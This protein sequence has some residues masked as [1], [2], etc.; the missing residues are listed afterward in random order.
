[1][2]LDTNEEKRR[3]LKARFTRLKVIEEERIRQMSI[4]KTST[5]PQQGWGW[6][7]CH[8]SYNPFNHNPDDKVHER[9]QIEYANVY[10][11]EYD[12]NEPEPEILANGNTNTDVEITKLLRNM[13]SNRGRNRGRSTVVSNDL[14]QTSTI[15]APTEKPLGDFE[16]NVNSY[17]LHKTFFQNYE[18]NKTLPVYKH[19]NQI[20]NSINSYSTIIIE[21]L[22][23]CG[24]TTQVPLYILEDAILDRKCHKSPVIYVTQPRRIAAKSIAERVCYEHNWVVGKGPVGFQVSLEKS[25]EEHTVLI[26]CTAGVLLQKLIQEKSL[27]SFTHIVIDEA[28]ER[29]ADTDLLLMM[30]RTLMRK[31]M[32]NFRLIIMSATMDT[33]KLKRYFTFRTSYGHHAFSTPS[34]IEIPPGR[35][36]GATIQIVQFD[37]LKSLFGVD[38]EG[39]MPNFEAENPDLH[40]TCMKTAVK[41][42]VDVI[43]HLDN[44][45]DDSN[46]TL[47]FLPGYAEICRLDRML[48]MVPGVQDNIDIIPLHS[49]LSFSDQ[50]RVFDKPRPG[51]RKVILA[52]NIAESSITV[53]DVGFIIDFCLTKTMLKDPVTRF[54]TLRLQWSSQDK[55]IQRAGRTGRCCSGKVFRMVPMQFYEAFDKYAKPELLTAPLELSVLRVK[56]FH[57]GELKALFAVVLDPPPY[58]EIRTAVLELKQIGALSST[59]KGK[60]SDIDGDLT[61]LG[62][63]ISNL[64][65]DVHLSKLIVIASVFDVVDNAIIIAACLSTN[66]TVVKHMYGNPVETYENKLEWANGSSSDLFVSLDV[67]KDYTHF[68]SKIR[69][70]DYHLVRRYCAKRGLDERKLDD[71]QA[72]NNEL[73]QRLKQVNIESFQQPNRE[74]IENEDNFMLKIA[75][76]AAFYPNYFISQEFDVQAVK[77]ELC[78]LDPRNTVVMRNIPVNQ[79]PLYR[80]QIVN[81]MTEYI[82]SDLDYIA[83]CSRALLVLKDEDEMEEDVDIAELL[84]D[85]NVLEGSESVKKAVYKACRMGDGGDS[86]EIREFNSFTA[87]D[88]MMFYEKQKQRICQSMGRK[89]MPSWFKIVDREPDNSRYFEA[90]DEEFAQLTQGY[91]FVEIQFDR[92]QNQLDQDSLRQLEKYEAVHSV[93]A[94]HPVFSSNTRKI[95]GPESPVRMSFKPILVKSRGF[96]VDV[97]P[98]SINAILLNPDYEQAR[99]QML[100]AASVNQTRRSRVL[101]RDTTLMPNVRGLAT[102]MS[103]LFAQYCRLVFNGRLKCIAGAIF[104]IGWDDFDKSLDNM[105][106]V[107][108]GFDVF[109]TPDDMALINKGREKMSELLRFSEVKN[110]GKPQADLQRQLRDI[111]LALVKRRRYPLRELDFTKLDSNDLKSFIV[112]KHNVP[113]AQLND[114]ELAKPFLPVIQMN[115]DYTELDLCESIRA[116]L[117]HLER[118][119]ND[120]EK[121]PR[122]GIYCLVCGNGWTDYLFLYMDIIRH[123]ESE[124]HEL[125]VREFEDFEQMAKQRA[126]LLS[127]SENEQ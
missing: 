106:E 79:V 41:I 21:G 32:P 38:V 116:N 31:E 89:L 95:R 121:P 124:K 63:I 7:A 29:D 53:P 45:C 105:Y 102:I 46:S 6:G 34:K 82:C 48:Q 109:I 126:R 127:S 27:G 120:Q 61:E 84:G 104:G 52:T 93:H 73:E 81:Q 117:D 28:H 54:P 1:M 44:Y 40:D 119:M 69:P 83:D 115:R 20:I 30:I 91:Y 122:T 101:A 108:L 87:H 17:D 5:A 60:L 56:N 55:C 25:A 57:M 65:I 68:K 94:E 39:P 18:S 2:S 80:D 97:D 107:E 12:T 110:A 123:L 71:V 88:R 72:L 47:V 59:Y 92:N 3:E 125:N 90:S 114:N 43:P 11:A 22:T 74:R 66:R 58:N 13:K 76:C 50:C 64:P 42:I 19:R 62:R 96:S 67:Y 85:S 75:F 112:E 8:D 10:R 14:E 36:A 9:E 113:K 4:E 26:Y 24:K 70:E 100:V 23:G 98:H 51:C 33:S 99:R 111:I 77:K 37:K 16:T 86:L 103:L 15:M 118:I 35:V 78:G 49:C